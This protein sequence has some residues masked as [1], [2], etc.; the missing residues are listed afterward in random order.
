MNAKNAAA[1]EASHSAGKASIEVITSLVHVICLLRRRNLAGQ[2]FTE[3]NGKKRKEN[4]VPVFQNG[5]TKG[6]AARL[7]AAKL[8][9]IPFYCPDQHI[10]DTFS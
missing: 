2:P 6:R 5:N 10:V 1:T 8:R 7:R 9:K 4:Q 3:S